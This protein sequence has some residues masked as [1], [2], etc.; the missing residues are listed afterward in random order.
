MIRRNNILAGVFVLLVTVG[1]VPRIIHAQQADNLNM[2]VSPTLLEINEAP[3]KTVTGKIRLRNNNTT[4]ITFSVYVDKLAKTTEGTRVPQKPDKEDTYTSWITFDKQTFTARPQEWTE[5]AYTLKIPDTAAFGYY[6][7]L[8]ISSAE[9][10]KK[11]TTKIVGEVVV[12]LLLQVEKTGA[13]SE[14]SLVDFKPKN[15]INQYLPVSF[16]TTLENK[17]NVHVKPRGNIFIKGNGGKDIAILEVNKEIGTILPTD[18]RSFVSEWTDGFLVNEPVLVDGTPKLND[19]G[20]QMT[21]LVAH[22]DKLTDFRFGKY[23]AK[24]IMVYDNGNKDVSLEASTTFWVIPYTP[25]LIAIGGLVVL[26]FI[27]KFSLKAYVR[28]QINRRQK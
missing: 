8:R 27:M 12:P 2:T 24:E 26:F 21:H 17:G 16:I 23:T 15:L 9:S 7:A 3:G 22:W 10:N 14:A 25:I 6:Y 18:K 1:F 13:K 19:K 4:P 5:I 20:Q 11:T 28:K